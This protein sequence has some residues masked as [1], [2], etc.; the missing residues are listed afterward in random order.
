MASSTGSETG[1]AELC[2]TDAD[3]TRVHVRIDEMTKQHESDFSKL[4]QKLNELHT[5]IKVIKNISDLRGKTCGVKVESMDKLL[6]GNG[7]SGVVSRVTVTEED[8]KG[9]KRL[10][11]GKEK[12][13]Y[14]IIG[15]FATA[16]VSCFIAM[17]THMLN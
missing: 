17:V 13:A 5:D 1:N 2:M 15:C 8:I 11:N 9:L 14:L 16:L 3:L 12:F 10:G 7:S 4:A 6:R